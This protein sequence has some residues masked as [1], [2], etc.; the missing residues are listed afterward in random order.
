MCSCLLRP[1]RAEIRV[2]LSSEVSLKHSVPEPNSA[3]GSSSTLKSGVLRSVRCERQL[4]G[5]EMALFRVTAS[6]LAETNQVRIHLLVSVLHTVVCY[7][8]L[9]LNVEEKCE[10]CSFLLCSWPTLSR[11]RICSLYWLQSGQIR[12]GLTSL[13]F[14]WRCSIKRDFC[15]SSVC[16]DQ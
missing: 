12:G 16:A 13:A 8:R 5:G 4:W 11:I 10:A 6:R 15:R 7:L 1:V 3:H 14:R 2:L 9:T